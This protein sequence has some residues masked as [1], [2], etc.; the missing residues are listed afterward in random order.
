MRTHFEF[1]NLIKKIEEIINN[2]VDF[3][4]KLISP[5]NIDSIIQQM[6]KSTQLFSLSDVYPFTVVDSK[7][8][9]YFFE[10]KFPFT[11]ENELEKFGIS[12]GLAKAK[13]AP[14]DCPRY[15]KRRVQPNL[16]ALGNGDFVSFY[17]GK[18]I[19]IQ[20]RL[21]I[22]L[23]D[24]L[25]SKTYGLKLKARSNLLNGCEFRVS[26]VKFDINLDAYFCIELLE[27]EI[28]AKVNP[29]LGRQ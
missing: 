13:D 12:W 7:P 17:L 25:L 21:N 5:E 10:V 11:D 18:R 6:K 4:N 8:G 19:N 15:Y 3:R 22:H 20:E 24:T 23:N 9:I 14:P 1:N 28:R 16:D 26:W 29:L 2:A 27:T